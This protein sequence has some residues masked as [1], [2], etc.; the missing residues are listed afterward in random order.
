MKPFLLIAGS[1]YYP[2]VGTEDWKGCFETKEK[3]EQ[4]FKKINKRN[5]SDLNKYDWYEIVDL[6]EWM[7][8]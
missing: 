5:G 4:Y 6:R 2:D 3:A 8:K 7:N 1:G